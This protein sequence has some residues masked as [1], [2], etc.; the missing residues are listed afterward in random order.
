MKLFKFLLLVAFLV[1]HP[2]LSSSPP[3]VRHLSEFLFTSCLL[4]HHPCHPLQASVSV[5]LYLS[6]PKLGK[7][8]AIISHFPR[9]F[10]I[11]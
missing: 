10:Q 7:R 11:E 9:V 3:P 5:S 4:L 2:I 6:I 8:R 1:H